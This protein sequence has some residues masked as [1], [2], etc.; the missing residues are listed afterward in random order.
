MA[1]VLITTFDRDE[2]VFAGLRAGAKGFLLKDAGSELLAQAIRAAAAGDALIAPNVTV[3]LLEAFAATA[4]TAPPPQ[5]IAPLTEREE[6]ILIKVARGL[7]NSEIASQLYITLST[8]KTHIASLM[9]KL[10]ARNRVEIAIWAHQ[11]GR[12]RPRTST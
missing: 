7:S 11:T 10:D 2:Y 8:V 6:Q 3:R 4:P 9:T 12:M 5:P 1:V